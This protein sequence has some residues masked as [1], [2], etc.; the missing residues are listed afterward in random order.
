[1]LVTVAVLMV[2]GLG[3]TLLV[4]TQADTMLEDERER[5]AALVESLAVPCAISLA[6][7]DIE[8]L[9]GYLEEVV[10]AGGTHLGML[11]VTMLDYEGRV[12]AHS[13]PG[14]FTAR[15][16]KGTHRLPPSDEA[17]TFVQEA[18]QSTRPL[19]R[20]YRTIEGKPQLDISMPAVSGLRWGTLVAGFDLRPFEERLAHT[21]T[22]LVVAAMAFT[23]TM[24][25]A[26]Y[27]GL[28]RIVV[29]PIKTLTRS[30]KKLEKGDLTA[31]AHIDSSGELQ[32]LANQ[33]NSM[34]S[35]LQ[36]YTESLEQKVEERAAEVRQKNHELEQVNTR[37]KEAVSK[38]EELARTDALTG[39]SNRRFLMEILVFELKRSQRTPRPLSLLMIDVDHFKRVNDLQ[40]HIVG[41]SVLQQLASNLASN[42]RSTDVVARYGGEEFVVLLFDTAL[43]I[44]I[45]VAEKIR[46]NIENLTFHDWDDNVHGRITVSIGLAGY[47][48]DA[49]EAKELIIRAD[50]ALYTAKKGGRNRVEKWGLTRTDQDS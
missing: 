40:G 11:H 37:L 24:F 6:T 25:L 10:Q 17:Q 49:Q 33:L 14:G 39:I 47:P 27:F 15:T 16:D 20:R 28:H 44:A 34:A 35:E 48:N 38:L 46:Q 23:L 45:E 9:D 4:R 41:D 43:E 42:L 3:G 31:R 29:R 26:L 5:A 8:R 12:I 32:L 2:M 1:M 30:A 13:G 50:R 36:S 7:N 22:I 18:V 21:R 19:W